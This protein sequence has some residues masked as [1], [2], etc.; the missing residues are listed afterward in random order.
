MTARPQQLIEL[1]SRQESLS[2]SDLERAVKL[3]RERGGLLA[4][5]LVQEGLMGE[6]DLFFLFSRELGVP[7]FPEERLLHLKLSATLRRKVPRKFAGDRVLIPLDLNTED[8][9]LS[10]VMFDPSD[11]GTLELLRKTCKVGEIRCY[12][13]RRSA[14]IGALAAAYDGPRKRKSPA[15]PVGRA[16]GRKPRDVSTRA[17]IGT[18]GPAQKAA[19]PRGAPAPRRAR[20]KQPAPGAGERPS[21]QPKAPVRP[22]PGKARARTRQPQPAPPAVRRE[23][24]APQEPKVEID[25]LLQREIAAMESRPGRMVRRHKRKVPLSEEATALIP[26]HVIDAEDITTPPMTDSRL[27]VE[28]RGRSLLHAVH[29]EPTKVFREIGVTQEPRTEE[30]D[31][32]DLVEFEDAA[33]DPTPAVVE[34]PEVREA[35]TEERDVEDLTEL[36]GQHLLPPLPPMDQSGLTPLPDITQM[37]E[38]DSLLRELLSSVGVLVSMLEERIDPAGGICREYGQLARMVAREAGMNELTVS[39]VALAAY[40]FALDLALRQEVGEA[41]SGDVC[42]TFS[43]DSGSP[44]GLGPSLRM[45]G[46]N[47][48]GITENGGSET[49]AARLLGVVA[50]YITLRTR[51]GDQSTDQGTMIQLLKAGGADPELVG[52]LGRALVTGDRTQVMKGPPGFLD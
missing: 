39:R 11:S 8:D 10:V 35:T 37:E 7:V 17:R 27:M 25:P 24:S 47:A 12:L 50:Q 22:G 45:L 29:S 48:L 28:V 18:A 14:I 5:L 31:L 51:S 16:S 26:R 2:A 13:A 52:A 30:L 4:D 1:I 34:L 44:G 9:Q 36:E 23:A 6:E 19:A 38:L 40:L 46:A 42:R 15:R 20:Q 43:M 21:G 33:D 49:P 3:H 41:G 32:N